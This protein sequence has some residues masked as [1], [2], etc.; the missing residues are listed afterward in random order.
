MKLTPAQEK[1]LDRVKA[2]GK[3]VQN[4]R[5]RKTIKALER[6][7]L[8]HVDWDARPQAKGSGVELVEVI[9]VTEVEA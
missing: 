7:G 1:L 8:V 2:E 9:T 3:L 4:G 5:A 6:A